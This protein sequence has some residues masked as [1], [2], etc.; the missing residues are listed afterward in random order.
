LWDTLKSFFLE[1]KDGYLKGSETVDN[2]VI[3]VEAES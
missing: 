2:V 3:T 1:E